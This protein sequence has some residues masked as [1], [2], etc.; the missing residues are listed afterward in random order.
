[1]QTQVLRT[2]VLALAMAVPSMSTA[3][4]AE[5]S[6]DEYKFWLVACD[7]VLHCTAKGFEAEMAEYPELAVSR[8]AGPDAEARVMIRAPFAV[9]PADL[10]VD[11]KP[12]G[13]PAEVW[14]IAR[15]GQFTTLSLNQ[16]QAIAELVSQ[17]H[18]AGKLQFG[19]HEAA[20]PLDGLVAALLR[21]DERQG[22][23]DDVSALIRRGAA[24]TSAV[25]PEPALPAKPVYTPAA[26][27]TNGEG[28]A[29][30]RRARTDLAHVFQED[31]CNAGRDGN[32]DVS[33]AYPLDDQHALVLI[34]CALGAYQSWSLVAIVP[35]AEDT[36]SIPFQPVLPFL[37]DK[38]PMVHLI[39]P[40][41]DP[42]TGTL[43]MSAKLRGLGDCGITAEWVWDGKAFRLT[44]GTYQ[45]ACGGSGPGEWPV[46][47]RSGPAPKTGSP[48]V[49]P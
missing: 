17:F 39:E 1:M 46:V 7:N 45:S 38:T 16:P 20:V 35:R 2:I 26:P 44:A 22:R 32:L 43:T 6:Y 13:L 21:M 30:L 31:D 11:G 49:S 47:Y 12:I 48:S 5:P 41:F 10:R 23:V 33:E 19:T 24:P 15:D 42:H 29:L 34:D 4:A 8:A 37:D 25:P 18:D 28:D 27:L 9:E 40:V 36:P 14:R 3:S